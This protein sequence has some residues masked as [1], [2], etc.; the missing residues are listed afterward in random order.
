MNIQVY[1]QINELKGFSSKSCTAMHHPK[2]VLMCPPDY[3]DVIDVKNP[4]MA[5]KVGTV[6]KKKAREQWEGVKDAF[7]KAG[8]KV[9]LISPVEG[10][11]DMIFCANQT[12]AGWNAIGER[13][14]VLSQMRHPSRRCEVPSFEAWFK[15]EGYKI[16]RLK[17]TSALFEGMGDCRWHPGRR[18]LW[19]GHGFRTDP[20]VYRE[21]AQTF[22]A[23]VVTL[24]LVNER[25]FHL[26]TCFCPLTPE[27][28]LIYPPAFGAES[29]E[30]ILKFFPIV[31]TAEESEAVRWLPCNATV[32][33]SKLAIVQKGANL[34]I[35][36]MK[37]VGLEVVEVDTSEFI[38]SGGSVSCMSLPLF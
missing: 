29:L 2:G 34:C 37:A 38:K 1:S 23:P 20:E 15:A 22:E 11:E 16:H 26:D 6:N 9:R 7:E 21:I 10:L 3:F 33:D 4:F 12:L 30:M 28:V 8:L 5:G 32:I 24:K 17:D 36:H 18:M 13:I 31:L 35:R 19:G 25:F 27:A 14:C